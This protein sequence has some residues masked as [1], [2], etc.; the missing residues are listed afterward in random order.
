MKLSSHAYIFIFKVS[1]LLSFHLFPAGTPPVTAGMLTN[2]KM[3]QGCE[4]VLNQ[5]RNAT[6]HKYMKK[7]V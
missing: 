1:S 5:K 3:D 2:R 7:N 6:G 4:D